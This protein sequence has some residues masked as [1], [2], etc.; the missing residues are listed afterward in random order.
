MLTKT[1]Y[2]ATCGVLFFLCGF[3]SLLLLL[4]QEHM[5]DFAFVMQQG[6]LN[7]NCSSSIFSEKGGGMKTALSVNC[8]KTCILYWIKDTSWMYGLFSTLTI[9]QIMLLGNMTV[10]S[11]FCYVSM[12]GSNSWHCNYNQIAYKWC[13]SSITW[14]YCVMYFGP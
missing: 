11:C 5:E 4:I 9:I 10:V 2:F 6:H 7:S 8:H 14:L 12:W 13:I 1:V 3:F